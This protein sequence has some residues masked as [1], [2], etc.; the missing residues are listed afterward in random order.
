MS[1]RT[2]SAPLHNRIASLRQARG[3]SRVAFAEALGINFQTVGY[4]EREEYAPSLD[5]AMRIAAYFDLPVESGFSRTIFKDGSAA[6][7]D[8]RA[9]ENRL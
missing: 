9:R 4:L 3:L 8:R 6:G 1:P 5:L 7:I 2:S